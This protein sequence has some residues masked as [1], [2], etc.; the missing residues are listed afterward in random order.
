MV[1]S[2]Q[3]R[4]ATDQLVL[5]VAVGGLPGQPRSVIDALAAGG[6]R[7]VQLDARM[8]GTRPH[9]LGQSARRDLAGVLKRRQLTLTGI[10]L[11][12]PEGAFTDPATQERA[13]D[14]TIECIQ[15]AADLGA[16]AIS[17][18]LP[19]PAMHA[20][21]RPAIGA[22]LTEAES[23]GVRVADCSAGAHAEAALRPHVHALGLDPAAVL[24]A[25]GDPVAAVHDWGDRLAAVR[26]DDVSPTGMRVPPSVDGS[27]RLDLM[28]YKVAVSFAASEIG[29][30]VV[31]DLRQCSDPPSA[32][33]QARSAWESIS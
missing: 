16:S 21:L 27:G 28:A 22:V 26:L 9:E 17:T 31:V 20:D 29:G 23:R 12:L 30:G 1:A 6:W 32:L 8:R 18:V 19:E 2:R 14:R 5:S 4:A 10:D 15:L 11:W 25:G 13:V 7:G 3:M 33:Q 24:T